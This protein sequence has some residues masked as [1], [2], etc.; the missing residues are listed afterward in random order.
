LRTR[1]NLVGQIIGRLTVLEIIGTNKRNEFI[2]RCCCTCGNFKETTGPALS[3]LKKF[4]SSCGCINKDG[5]H[6]GKGGPPALD[7]TG[8][9]FGKLTAIERIGRKY[10]HLTATYWKCQCDCG[11]ITEVSLGHLRCGTTTSCGH[12]PC[13]ASWKHGLTTSYI[14]YSGAKHRAKIKN[15]PFNLELSDLPDIP[16]TCP[17]LGIPI[18]INKGHSN[19]GHGASLDRI[20]PDLGYVKGNIRIISHR[21]NTLKSN[22]TLEEFRKIVSDLENINA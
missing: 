12:P 7:I 1:K 11:R 20:K 3:R 10:K 13:H 4:T 18:L 21:A 14:L 9:K 8:Q 6:R 22:G 5:R 2:Y 16:K 19:N 15:I 17:V